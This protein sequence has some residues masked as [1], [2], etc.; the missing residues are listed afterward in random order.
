MS[1]SELNRYNKFIAELFPALGSFGSVC[2]KKKARY[3]YTA[4]MLAR[5]QEM[6]IYTG[7]PDTM[8]ARMLELYMQVNGFVCV[9]EVNGSLYAFFGGLGGMPDAY[10]MPTE[11]IVNNPALDFNKTL[12]IGEDCVII[13]NDSMY[14]GLMPMYA[15]YSELMAESD[16]TFRVTSINTR[17]SQV[18]SAS[19][20]NTKKAAEKY[21]EKIEAGELGVIGETAFLDGIKLQAGADNTNRIIDQIEY[22][23]YLKASWFNELGI[24]A[25]F[26]MK[27]EALGSD[28]VQ[29][30]IKA[31]LPL[32]QDMLE[33]RKKG[34]EAVNAKFGTNITVDF[35]GVWKDTEQEAL[36][37]DQ[38]TGEPQEA[39]EDPAQEQED[40]AEDPEEQEAA[41]DEQN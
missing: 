16:I 19:D 41:E 22:H 5:T 26:N 23:Q 34:V 25:A 36:Q 18:L 12:K 9:T 14:Q 1:S 13:P 4:Y 32:A 30:N 31:L 3:S 24:Q 7:L 35:K 40:P 10:Y 2:D 38:L 28:E 33:Q 8:P 20:D 27:R 37:T 29:L 21:L 11:C 17:M 6:F 15:K 39:P